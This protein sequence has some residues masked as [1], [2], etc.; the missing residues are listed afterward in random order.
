ML[1]GGGGGSRENN[2][3][4]EQAPFCAT[5]SARR[6][7]TGSEQYHNTQQSARTE[8]FYKLYG[9]LIQ[10]SDSVAARLASKNDT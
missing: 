3:L 1:G 6:R 8:T 4:K 2:E 9:Q 10:D 7:H 5:E